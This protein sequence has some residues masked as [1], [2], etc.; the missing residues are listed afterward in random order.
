MTKQ[1]IAIILS[2]SVGFSACNSSGT[3]GDSADLKNNPLLQTSD[4]PFGAPDFSVIQN[5]HFQPALEEGMRQQREAVQAIIENPEAPSFENTIVA[6]EKSGTVLNRVNAVF[7]A[8]AGAHTND[9]IQAI[10]EV[11]IPKMAAHTDAIYLN[12][13]LFYR[14]RAL[15]NDK[16]ALAL[17]P[18]SEKLLSFY[19]EKFEK[20]GAALSIEDKEKLK[21]LNSALAALSNTFRST[22]LAATN[23]G[24]VLIQDS[25]QLTG[26][27]TSEIQALRVDEH[28]AIPLQNTT[29]QPLL[30]SLQNR[31]L[32]ATLYNAS[33]NRAVGKVNNTEETILKITRLRAEKAALLGFNNY[34]EWSLQGTMAKTPEQVQGLFDQLIPAATEKAQAEAVAI[35]H[36]IAQQGGDFTLEAYDWNFYAEQVKKALYDLDERQIRPYFV[37]DSVLENGVFYA[38]ERLYGLRFKKRMDIPTYHPDV[39]VY[40]VFD[41][42]E[43]P[44]GLFYGDYFKRDSKRGGAWMSNFLSQSRL[45]DQQ[46]V[47]YNVCNF[48]K[49]SEGTAALLSFDEALTMF[50]EFGHALHGFFADQTYPSLSGTSV[51]RDFV[52]FPSQFNEHW[53]THPEILQHYAKHYETGAVIPQALLTKLE[54]AA[55]FNQGYALTENLAAS[56]LDMQWHTLSMDDIVKDVNAFE[57]SALHRTKLDVVHAVPPRYRSTY[58]SH[59]FGS[60][61]AA[62]Y[63]SYL[64]TEMLDHDAYEWFKQHGGLTRENG[65]R[66]RDMVLSRGNTQDYE[67]LY[68]NWRGSDPSIGPFLKA[69]GIE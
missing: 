32:R 47:I 53:A 15:Y 58:F 62:G 67:S 41:A 35:Q 26:L 33:Y 29:Q 56:N 68:R 17:D 22:L 21:S 46:P 25:S 45:L 42:D 18:E 12:E 60:G 48:T 13:P 44:L 1:S 7:S 3:D 39:L 43:S 11:I 34:A 49:P 36:I 54:A 40:E 52:E 28:W 19:Y 4:L 65:Q 6:L 63:Y 37:L 24:T 8:L 9:S 16:D 5:A 50:H 14:I 23:A 10:Q 2:L 20:A 64:W 59:I 38:A 55:T 31:D 27:S 51:A 69:R 57:K 61:Y 30:Q 66:F